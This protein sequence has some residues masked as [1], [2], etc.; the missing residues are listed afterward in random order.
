MKRTFILA[1][2]T[3]R[4]NAL[5]AVQDAPQG[6][7][8]VISEPTRTLEQNAAQWPYL[9]GFAQQKQAV[10]NGQLQWVVA[11]DWKDILTGAYAGE[12]RVAV[13]DGKVI[14]L[15][16]RTSKMGRGAFSSWMDFLVAMADQCGVTPVYKS[17]RQEVETC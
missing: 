16:L 3:A 1:H 12:M 4:R 10:I 5:Q 11:D 8:V 6:Y 14:M 13:F 7:C 15:P 17:A 9:E 2:D